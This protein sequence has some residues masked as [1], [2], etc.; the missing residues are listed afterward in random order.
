MSEKLKIGL[1]DIGTCPTNSSSSV[2]NN[3]LEIVPLADKLGFSRYWL[4]EHHTNNIAW[5]DPT[6]L[7]PTLL[8]RTNRIKIGSAGVLMYFHN[9]LRLA[10]NYMLLETIYPGRIDLGMARGLI[11]GDLKAALLDY[12]SEAQNLEIF[13][14]KTKNLISFLRRDF[15]AGHKYK[16][17][18]VMPE[19][20]V[21]PD[22]W[23]LGSTETL[24]P[25]AVN[26]KTSFCLALFSSYPNKDGIKMFKEKWNECN[27]GFPVEYS[28]CVAGVCAETNTEA[29]K[30][31]R[32]LETGTA[33]RVYGNKDECREQILDLSDKYKVSE[34]IFFELSLEKKEKIASYNLLSE[35]FNLQERRTSIS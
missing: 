15:P 35:A 24:I 26:H 3:L 16:N 20:N 4:G 29:T 5:G 6:L 2:V 14:E 34:V 21:I 27:A 22:L 13:T 30:I 31:L 9:S 7:I 17:I 18:T 10:Q 32:R 1:L 11:E 8:E 12:N 23:M 25:L 33:F 28:I 19:S